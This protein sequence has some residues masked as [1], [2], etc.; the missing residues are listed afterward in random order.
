VDIHAR[1]S[2]KIGAEINHRNHVQPTVDVADPPLG[3]IKR[4][5]ELAKLADSD[6]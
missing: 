2:A 6:L 1:Q 5:L 3:A 4:E